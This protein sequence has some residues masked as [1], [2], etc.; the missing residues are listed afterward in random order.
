[1]VIHLIIWS[2]LSSN[3]LCSFQTRVLLP[4]ILYICIRVMILPF[5]K[6][7]TTHFWIGVKVFLIRNLLSAS[8]PIVH[9][10]YSSTPNACVQL[11]SHVPASLPSSIFHIAV[12]SS[13][14]IESFLSCFHSWLKNLLLLFMFG[15]EKRHF[16]HQ[17]KPPAP[18]FIR[19]L[20]NCIF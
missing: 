14:S 1:M 15:L 3:L 7:I 11:L 17:L 9:G 16:C 20:F 2:P 19:S 12:S 18:I 6:I 13:I 8:H 10:I 5:L 4:E